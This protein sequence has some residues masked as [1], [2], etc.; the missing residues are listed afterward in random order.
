M[1]IRIVPLLSNKLVNAIEVF[2]GED[3][4]RELIAMEQRQGTGVIL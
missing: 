3:G 1:Y 4:D 2:N